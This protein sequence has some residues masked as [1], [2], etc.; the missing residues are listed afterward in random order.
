[1]PLTVR[2]QSRAELAEAYREDV[3]AAFLRVPH[4]IPTKYLY[5]ARGAELFRRFCRSSPEHYTHRQQERWMLTRSRDL[6]GMLHSRVVEL[7]PGVPDWLDAALREAGGRNELHYCALDVAPKPLLGAVRLLLDRHRGLTVEA[8]V[9]DYELWPPDN[10]V[11]PSQPTSFLWLGNTL[12]NVDAD[13]VVRLLGG[14]S[15]IAHPESRLVVGVSLG[16]DVSA[17]RGN[18]RD[19]NRYFDDFCWNALQRMERELSASIQL[20]HFVLRS[21]YNRSLRRG[22]SL[23]QT[24]QDTLVELPE[25]ERT[26]R[27][28]EGDEVVVGTRVLYDRQTLQDVM[29]RAGW[30]EERFM[31]LSDSPFAM[32]AFGLSGHAGERP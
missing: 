25:A 1:M 8:H 26:V 15:Q 29:K 20:D 14:I 12:A 4:V 32:V 18:Y 5:D 3:T 11:D 23:F 21:T 24:R 28:G 9:C 22:E 13:A 2:H 16:T 30:L 10:Y 7:G 19:G 31:P 27:L 6:T 17:F